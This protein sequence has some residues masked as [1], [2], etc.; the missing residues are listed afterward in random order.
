M[1]LAKI[2]IIIDAHFLVGLWS[3]VRFDLPLLECLSGLFSRH[4]RIFGW[5]ETDN[6]DPRLTFLLAR[7]TFW[8]RPHL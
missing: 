4:C 7:S 5:Q 2:V 6:L 1:W 8:L 3:F